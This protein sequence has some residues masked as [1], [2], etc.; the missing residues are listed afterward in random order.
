MKQKTLK[1]TYH[2]EGKG[3]HTGKVASLNIKP[4]PENSG[5]VFRRVDKG[6]DIPASARYVSSTTRS[7][8]LSRDGVSVATIEHL[9]SALTG[10]GVDN[11]LV[12]IDNEEVPILD[13]SARYYAEA[14]AADGLEEQAAERKYLS[15]GGVIEKKDEE[16][17]SWVRITPADEFS[18]DA[19]IDFG[20][21]ILG[22]QKVHWDETVDYAS[23]IGICRTFCFYHELECLAGMGL[24]KGGDMNNA[25]VVVGRDVSQD[26]VDKMTDFFGQP[27]LEVNPD[28]YLNNLELHFKD[29]CGRHKL[30]DL[31]GD[32][33]L[34]G[35]YLKAHVEA[36]KP[37]HGINTAA[38]ALAEKYSE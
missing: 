16:S 14:I 23:Q 3:L 37:G 20:S 19:E 38:A 35:G 6:I 15:P 10:M 9:M 27:H 22:V 26:R 5:I 11:A 18:I 32:I 2:F 28:G 30:L 25:I 7:T 34:S 17:G 36:F 4:A 29:E 13:G 1:N 8:T 33:R 21:D 24:V 31:I 12:E